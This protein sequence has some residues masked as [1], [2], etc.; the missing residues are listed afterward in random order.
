MEG[1]LDGANAQTRII[2]GAE[3]ISYYN[4][5][6]QAFFDSYAWSQDAAAGLLGAAYQDKW[7][8]NGGVAQ[9]FYADYVYGT[10][11]PRSTHDWSTAVSQDRIRQHLYHHLLTADEYVWMYTEAKQ[12][13]FLNPQENM[14][15]GIKTA[16]Q[17][18]YDAFHKGEALGF[19]L[20]SYIRPGQWTK[21]SFSYNNG[22]MDFAINDHPSGYAQYGAGNLKDA[23]GAFLGYFNPSHPHYKGKIDDVRFYSAA[24]EDTA[25][26]IAHWKLDEGS[27]SK[28]ADISGNNHTGTVSGATWTSGK[29]GKALYF[30]GEDDRVSLPD[31]DNSVSN[32]M[33]MSCWINPDKP[34]SLVYQT[35]MGTSG[36]CCMI[37]SYKMAFFTQHEAGGYYPG[38]DHDPME[39]ITAP[40]VTIT[41]PAH[42]GTVAD[43]FAIETK[44]S[45]SA[46][47]VAF[48]INSQLVGEDKTAPY[49]CQVSHLPKGEY[50]IVAR[51]F[52][53]NG[54]HTSS[55]P[56]IV[57]QPGD[58]VIHGERSESVQHALLGRDR[59]TAVR[60]ISVDGRIV[61]THRAGR[62]NAQ[63]L[64][65]DISA[66]GVFLIADQI[67]R[68]LKKHMVVK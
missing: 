21:L 45:G 11:V 40:T 44:V 20:N 34:H 68:V 57:N 35:I 33:T 9:A 29:S 4:N 16:L 23:G 41:S 53:A 13:W 38:W 39:K 27:G 42:D 22:R 25:A 47:K 1:M 61:S 46:D 43:A 6:A 50:L 17:D 24:T 62:A 14:W 7:A 66:G 60:I 26:L 54:A 56:V 32:A 63:P 15:P 59:I 28:V 49:T 37:R 67:G 10:Y 2:D 8:S 18:A 48:Y 58:A 31:I 51:V 55:A 5:D 64:R 30:D 12:K 3:S 52:D 19:E 65:Q 36:M